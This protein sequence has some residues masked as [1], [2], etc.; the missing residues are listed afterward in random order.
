[1]AARMQVIVQ[2]VARF[3]VVVPCADKEREG[4]PDVP[5]AIS[6]PR[7]PAHRDAPTLPTAARMATNRRRDRPVGGV[8]TAPDRRFPVMLP[9]RG[10][11]REPRQTSYRDRRGARTSDRCAPVLRAYRQDVSRQISC[12]KRLA[13]ARAAVTWHE[14]CFCIDVN[15]HEQRA[16]QAWQPHRVA[17]M[18][19]RSPEVRAHVLHCC[20][21][22]GHVGVWLGAGQHER[23]RRCSI[24]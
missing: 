15:C 12:K 14:M 2:S 5:D 10:P 19:L 16:S 23:R 1:M 13:G 9:R 3:G 21:G 11:C 20:A 8:G 22:R 18:N 6:E 24:I 4:R 17:A 7:I